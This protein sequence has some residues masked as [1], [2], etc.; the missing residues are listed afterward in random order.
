MIRHYKGYSISEDLNGDWHVLCQHDRKQAVTE[1]AMFRTE[2]EAFA[3][4]D[5]VE[6]A[7]ATS[8]RIGDTREG[9]AT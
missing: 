7:E 1:H 3:W 8:A 2:A 9:G 5:R 6:S 4:V